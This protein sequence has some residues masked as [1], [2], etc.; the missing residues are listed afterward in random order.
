MDLRGNWGQAS[1]SVEM[2]VTPQERNLGLMN[3]ESLPAT[4]GMLFVFNP[5]RSVSFWMRNTLIPLDMIFLDRQ[6]VVQGIHENAVPLDETPIPGGDR[7]F[8]VL[9]INGG[10][11]EELGIAPGSQMRHPVFGPSAEWSCGRS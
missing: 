3:R 2:A 11:S 10:L 5:P 1:F 8:A 9:E 6:G 7:I 4:A